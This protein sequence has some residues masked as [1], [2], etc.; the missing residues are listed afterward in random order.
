MPVHLGLTSAI[1]ATSIFQSIVRSEEH[2][3]A[4]SIS[5]LHHRDTTQKCLLCV[6][7]LRSPTLQRPASRLE[8]LDETPRN[9]KKS[10]IYTQYITWGFS[11]GTSSLLLNANISYLNVLQGLGL[12]HDASHPKNRHS[13]LLGCPFSD[14]ALKS[15]QISVFVISLCQET[16]C[17][18]NTSVCYSLL[19]AATSSAT[20]NFFFFSSSRLYAEKN[21][22]LF[23]YLFSY[24]NRILSQCFLIKKTQHRLSLPQACACLRI[25]QFNCF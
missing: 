5:R 18:N 6:H 25:K 10:V 22:L 24:F 4:Q 9:D 21:E 17:I 12:R 1:K 15:S 19:T 2:S 8:V 11:F 16:A 23:I 13:W 14:G 3:R 20:L 7:E